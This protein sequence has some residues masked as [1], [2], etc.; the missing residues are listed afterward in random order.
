MCKV[1]GLR[2][3]LNLWW[4]S[5][6]RGKILILRVEAW[7]EVNHRLLS[8]DDL[9]NKGYMSGGELINGSK[10]LNVVQDII[11]QWFE[12]LKR[13]EIHMGVTTGDIGLF[14]L[15]RYRTQTQTSEH[16]TSPY[17]SSAS[18]FQGD[19]YPLS[20][21]GLGDFC[22]GWF[23]KRQRLGNLYTGLFDND[24]SGT[25]FNSLDGKGLQFTKG[26]LTILNSKKMQ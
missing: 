20:K 26:Q 14:R 9:K 11:K 13:L 12:E 21:G 19:K 18:P 17:P 24:S 1:S 23:I 6:A 22:Y 8:I 10:L 5:N 7:K 2:N 16:R 4:V 15:Y 3:P 25:L